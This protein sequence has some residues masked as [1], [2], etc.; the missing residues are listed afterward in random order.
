MNDDRIRGAVDEALGSAKR[1]LGKLTGD[2]ETEVEGA[3]QQ[4]KG[5]VESAIGKLKDGLK[6]PTPSFDPGEPGQV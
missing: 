3:A 5:K 6:T 4:I 2:T 1:H